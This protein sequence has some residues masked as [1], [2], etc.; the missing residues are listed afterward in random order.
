MS[1]KQEHKIF[2]HVDVNSAFLSWSAIKELQNGS[3]LDLRTIPSAVGGDVTKRHGVILAKSSQAK[4]Y[5]VQTGESVYAARK[6]CPE[7]VLVSPDFDFYVEKSHR[8]MEIMQ[9][10]SPDI[11]QY[12]I[13]EAFLDMTGME[14]LFGAPLICAGKLAKRVREEL[15]FTVNIGVSS[16]RLLAKMASDFEK[17]DKIHT[18]FPEEVP[19]K[20]WPLP[21]GELFRVGKSSVSRLQKLGIYTIGDAAR[22]DRTFLE[23]QLGKFGQMV[24][25]Y[26]NGIESVPMVR[27]AVKDNSCGNSITTSHD[28]TDQEEAETILLSLTETVGARLRYSG[29]KASVVTVQLTLSDF[30][31]ISHQ[32]SLEAA[33]NTTDILYEAGVRLL[34]QLWHGEPFRLIGISAGKASEEAYEQMSLFPDPRQEKLARLDAAMDM[35][36]SRYGENAVVRARLLSMR[37]KKDQDMEAAVPGKGGMAAARLRAQRQAGGALPGQRMKT[38]D[39]ENFE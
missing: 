17:P 37:Q 7:L 23:S 18:L 25:D 14:A 33:T 4:L 9:D 38:D 21:V 28:I 20:M 5:G 24:W 2:F 13:D 3:T 35:V 22:A 32:T 12:S 11:E 15:G 6:K 8:L 1:Q 16:N 19:E 10:F 26:A 27:E 29:K 31:R 34:R 36:R 30:R 39:T